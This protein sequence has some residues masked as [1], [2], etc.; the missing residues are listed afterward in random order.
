MAVYRRGGQWWHSFI[1]AGKRVQESAR[2]SRKTLAVEAG[3]K[4]RLELEKALA[5]VPAE[6]RNRRVQ[7][8]SDFIKPYLDTYGINHRPKSVILLVVARSIWS[9]FWATYCSPTLPNNRFGSTSKPAWR[10]GE[11]GAPPTWNSVS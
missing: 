1:F 3:K 7:S 2:T 11:A 5:G 10:K 9:D 8:V 6:D 4:R